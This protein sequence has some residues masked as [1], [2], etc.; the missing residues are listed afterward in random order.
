MLARQF[1]DTFPQLEGLRFTHAWGGAIDTSTRFFAFQRTALGGRVAY[2]VGYTGLGVGG[3]PLRCAGDAR[4]ARRPRRPRRPGCARYGRGRCRSR[5]NRRGGWASSSPVAASRAPTGGRAGAGR[6]CAR[7]TGSASASTPEAADP[8]RR[9]GRLGR[10]ADRRPPRVPV[11][12]GRRRLRPRPGRARRW[13]RPATTGSPRPGSTPPTRRRSRRCWPTQRIDAVLGATDPRFTMPIFRA[14]LAAGVHYLDMAMS[15]SRPHPTDP[16][17]K[18]GVKL[19]DEQFALA[20]EWERVGPARARRH[21]RRARP[22]GRVRALRRRSPVRRDRRGRR[23]RRRR[24]SRSPAYDFA[25]SFSIWTTIEECLNPPVDLRE[26]A[27][28]VHHR[29]VQRAGDVRLPG[30]H[31]ARSSA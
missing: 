9:R 6:G 5:R 4:P 18:T 11:R 1:F 12:R 3:D 8:R 24:T 25:P 22:G 15:L 16:Y 7:S 20:D 10:R 29:A 14:A 23:A 26:G 30:R 2:S 19:G 13:P 21:G 31:R 28:L 27:R 17:A